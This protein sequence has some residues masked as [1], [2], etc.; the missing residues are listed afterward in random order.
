M[1]VR[2][3]QC[4]CHHHHRI[5]SCCSVSIISPPGMIVGALCSSA[6]SGMGTSL[7]RWR[8][9]L[10]RRRDGLP[11]RRDGLPRSG[12]S[13]DEG[14]CGSSPKGSKTEVG[15]DGGSSFFGD[16]RATPRSCWHLLA[17]R[18]VLLPAGECVLAGLTSGELAVKLPPASA[19]K[20]RR[21]S[22]SRPA[23]ESA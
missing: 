10:P 19:S 9:G 18:I 16:E 14:C 8:D 1:T 15:S 21:R 3:C 22:S 5:M 2:Q 20:R 17:P 12:P 4:Q 7:P 13:G 6:F 23:T 11:R